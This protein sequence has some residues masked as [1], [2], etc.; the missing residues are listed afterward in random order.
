MAFEVIA[1]KQKQIWLIVVVLAGLVLAGCGDFATYTPS[2]REWSDE[3]QATIEGVDIA[4]IETLAYL[5]V[6]EKQIH[7]D[8]TAQ[9][10]IVQTTVEAF[11]MQAES[12]RVV[13]TRQAAA[14]TSAAWDRAVQGTTAANDRRLQATEQAAGATA[15][16]QANAN[17]TADARAVAETAEAR[18]VEGTRQTVAL[19]ATQQ[20]EQW[21][22][23]ATSTAWAVSYQA[24]AQAEYDARRASATAE[25]VQATRD[26]HQAT[27]TRAAEKREENLGAVR[28]YGLP[29][30]ALVIIVAAIVGLVWVVKTYLDRPQPVQRS[31]LGDALPMMHKTRDGRWQFLDTDRQPGPVIELLPNGGASAPQLRSPAQEE[32]TTARD[33]ALDGVS[34]PRLGGGHSAQPL[35]MPEPPQAQP[36]G[37]QGVRILRTLGQGVTA[38]L[39]PPGQVEAIEA[40]WSESE[41]D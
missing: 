30:F 18:Q 25:V 10:I 9:S 28:D 6:R 20:H 35:P 26:S 16:A 1:M 8:A 21:T 34:R 2:A 11:R 3:T 15:Q 22:M 36:E 19:Q 7:L 4:A 29:A 33:Q 12:Q 40:V 37:L 31:M 23:A 13:A 27:A 39:L 5:E 17:A 14:A 38:G 32:R 24:T 41:D